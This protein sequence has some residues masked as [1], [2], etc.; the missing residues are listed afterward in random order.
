MLHRFQHIADLSEICHFQGI[1]HIV[2]SPG[3]RNAPLIDTFYN[4]FK[5]S[6]YSIV[7]ERSAGYFA[8][9]IARYTQETVVLLCTSGTAVLNYS[10]SIAEAY[11]AHVPLLIIT[12]DRP[13]KWIDQQDN[14]T[15]RQKEVYRNFIKK[16]YHLPDDIAKQKILTDVHNQ[17]QEAINYTRKEP[18]GPVHI[19]VPI[20]EPLYIDLPFTS[21][22]ISSITLSEQQNDI[23][24]PD[25]FSNA[26]Q[27]AHKILI[28]HGQDHI[29]ANEGITLA[30]LS[31]FPGVLIIAENISNIRSENI[32]SNPELLLSH[33]STNSLAPPDLLLYSGG[34]IVSKKLKNYL[35][36]IRN[37]STWRIGID[38]Y[39]M[40]TFKQ[41]NSILSCPASMVYAQLIQVK[42]KGEDEYGYKNSWLKAS[43]NLTIKKEQII[44]QLPFSDISAVEH[45][46]KYVPPKSILELGNSSIVRLFQLFTTPDNTEV[47][48][49]RGVSGIDG[50]LSTASGTALVSSGL[51]VAVIG[52][53]SFIYDSNAMWNRRLSSKLRIVV[54]NNEG[55]GIFSLLDGPSTKS[56]YENYIIAHHPVNLQK[57][58]EAFNLN[59]FCAINEESLIRE[60]PRF[61][62]CADKA[63]ILEIK[64]ER[65]NNVKAFHLIMGIDNSTD[66]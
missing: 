64:T 6:C 30:N 54:M 26:W 27:N 35:R 19:N 11:Y 12:A 10:P 43:A 8:L 29:R 41:Q 55:G 15:I 9:G 13:G 44:R 38:N 48:S 18:K 47:Y 7:D 60:L 14:Q 53:L 2:I 31:N 36:N 50:C 59:Y 3:S 49:N 4:R 32:I 25:E 63:G 39:P 20:D 17:I 51:T 21:K 66:N 22:I 65:Q 40:D 42:R 16:S 45:I 5:D 24:L 62:T 23:V 33:T 56:A 28:L 52:D 34:Q 61:F 37:L 58:A 46:L 1:R 57:L